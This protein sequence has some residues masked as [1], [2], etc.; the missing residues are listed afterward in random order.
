MTKKQKEIYER[1]RRFLRAQMGNFH[2]NE[3]EMRKRAEDGK[4][5]RHLIICSTFFR[6]RETDILNLQMNIFGRQ[7]CYVM[8]IWMS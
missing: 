1:Y 6:I 5:I 4:K 8:Q 7:K 2:A 3:L